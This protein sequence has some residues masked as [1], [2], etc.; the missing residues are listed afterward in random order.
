MSVPDLMEYQKNK[1]N[2]YCRQSEFE[3][4]ENLIKISDGLWLIASVVYK[5][6]ELKSVFNKWDEVAIVSPEPMI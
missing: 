1:I 5:N 3:S 2:I 6:M 4:P